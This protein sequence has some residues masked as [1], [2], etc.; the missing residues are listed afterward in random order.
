MDTL[1]GF[2]VSE[3][4]INF[5]DFTSNLPRPTQ[6]LITLRSSTWR[7]HFLTLVARTLTK[8]D[9]LKQHSS[10]VWEMT[11]GCYVSLY[12]FLKV[13]TLLQTTL[14]KLVII[15]NCKDFY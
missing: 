2:I 15:A 1:Y 12:S 13:F 11:P 7:H 9:I 10:N 6:N 8:P 4:L 14:V 5:N 3:L